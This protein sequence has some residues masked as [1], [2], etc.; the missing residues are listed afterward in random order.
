VTLFDCYTA[1]EAFLTGT[2]AEVI[3]MVRLDGREI[4]DGKPGPVTNQ[5]IAAFRKETEVNGPAY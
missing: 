3:P 2:A 5:L 4:G 1:E